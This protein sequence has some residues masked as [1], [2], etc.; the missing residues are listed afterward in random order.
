MDRDKKL[1]KET[2]IEVLASRTVVPKGQDFYRMTESRLYA[3]PILRENIKRYELDIEDLK[4]EKFT[5][6]SKDITCWMGNSGGV[7]LSPQEQQEGKILA[8]EIKKAKDQAEIDTIDEAM[9]RL[10][11]DDA[12]LITLAYMRAVPIADI[13]VALESNE[14]A[15]GK[16]KKRIVRHLAWMLY[17]AE[18]LG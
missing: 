14:I 18:A 4:R 11:L 2:I 13:A 6:K 7:R 10:S 15:V 17:G 8:V 1:I 3:Y 9:S 16:D 5:T 12:N